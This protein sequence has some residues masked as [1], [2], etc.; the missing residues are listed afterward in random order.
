MSLTKNFYG[1]VYMA[2]RISKKLPSL[3]LYLKVCI[4]NLPDFLVDFNENAIRF[5]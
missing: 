5:F 2:F 1:H 4:N 3:S